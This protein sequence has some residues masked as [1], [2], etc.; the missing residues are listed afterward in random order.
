MYISVGKIPL[1]KYMWENHERFNKIIQTANEYGAL[2]PECHH[3]TK[4]AELNEKNASY[5]RLL[6]AVALGK[7][8]DVYIEEGACP[9][10]C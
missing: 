4:H 7:K 1:C 6:V 3:E 9:H 8:Y 10:G 5:D 2:A